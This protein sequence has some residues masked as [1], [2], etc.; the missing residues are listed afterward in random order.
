MS[1]Y[2]VVRDTEPYAGPMVVAQDQPAEG[3]ETAMK[4]EVWAVEQ[5]LDWRWYIVPVEATNG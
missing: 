3:F 1:R 4:A 2:R 5:R